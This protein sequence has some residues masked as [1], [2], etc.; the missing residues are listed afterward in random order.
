MFPGN[1]VV[2]FSQQ[3]FP[4]LLLWNKLQ[5]S[6]NICSNKLKT[7]TLSCS[8]ATTDIEMPDILIPKVL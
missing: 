2:P 4:L 5:R 8:A 7:S 1:E 3:T 6:D